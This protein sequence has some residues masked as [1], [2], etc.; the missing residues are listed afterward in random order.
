LDKIAGPWR[1]SALIM[2]AVHA[3]LVG[4]LLGL[5]VAAQPGPVSFL[6]V[7]T[8]ARGQRLPALMVGLAAACVDMVFAAFGAAG[9]AP[10]LGW[11]AARIALGLAGGA[12]LV[13]LG[14]RILWSTRRISPTPP[15]AP[16]LISWR[17]ALVTGLA[18]TA[19]NPLTIASW[20]AIFAAASVSGTADSIGEAVALIL[21]IGTAS[22]FWFVVLALTGGAASRRLG[23][24][25]LSVVDVVCGFTLTVFGVLL[26]S[27]M[28]RHA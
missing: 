14:L 26:I 23:P 10:L 7:R 25:S 22:C 18:V 28:F 4:L 5:L 20:G 19:S 24:R 16:E 8:A 2:G 12:F 27:I 3:V 21:G 11:P 17:R 1:R 13:F 9:A 15:F 6:L